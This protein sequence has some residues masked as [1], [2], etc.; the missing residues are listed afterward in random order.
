MMAYPGVQVHTD[1]ILG[2]ILY[3]LQH[4]KKDNKF[5]EFLESWGMNQVKDQIWIFLPF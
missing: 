5:Q 3:R 2:L 1:T 4:L